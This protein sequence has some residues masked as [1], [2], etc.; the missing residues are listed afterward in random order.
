LKNVYINNKKKVSQLV[1]QTSRKKLATLSP[2]LPHTIFT[3]KTLGVMKG[4][5]R[6]G[7]LPYPELMDRK[8]V[9]M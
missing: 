1:L 4:R 6:R 5:G 2:P 3:W 8:E 7:K 9:K